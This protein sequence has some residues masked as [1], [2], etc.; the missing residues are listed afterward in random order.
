MKKKFQYVC[1]GTVE[2]KKSKLNKMYTTPQIAKG[3]CGGVN[4]DHEVMDLEPQFQSQRCEDASFDWNELFSEGYIRTVLTEGVGGIG[5]TVCIQKF[6]LDWAE[7]KSN[8]HFNF[9]FL[10][11]FRILNSIKDD[12][13][14]L[15]ELL[16]KFNPELEDLSYLF[17][18]EH[19]KVLFIFDGLDESQL[20]FRFK[21]TIQGQSNTQ[22]VETVITSLIKGEVLPS[23]K[24]LITSRPAATR[25]IPREHIHLVLEAQGFSDLQKEQYFRKNLDITL[26]TQVIKH[27]KS[28]KSL[29]IMCHMP[30]FCWISAT[31]YMDLQRTG[32]WKSNSTEFPTTL[33]EM[34]IH[35]LNVQLKIKN[36]KLCDKYEDNRFLLW[37]K[38]K[39]SV[40]KLAKLA[41][42][43]LDEN[44]F[45][46]SDNH[47]ESHGIDVNEATAYS[48]ILP[49][50]S[51][52]DAIFFKT[53]MYC[54]VHP[55]IQ[56]FLA[57]LYVFHAFATQDMSDLRSLVSIKFNALP[58]R[59]PLHAVLNKAVDGALGSANGHLDLFLR[60]LLGLSVDCS[61]ELLLGL[62]SKKVPSSNSIK[63]A[64]KT[65]NEKYKEDLPPERCINLFYCLLEMK[66][67]T[68]YQEIKEYV[69]SGRTELSPAHCSALASILLMSEEP[70][71]EFDLRKYNTS[72]EGYRRLVPVVKWCKKAV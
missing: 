67:T 49:E 19:F 41:L 38:N 13:L 52:N 39:Q 5:K 66:N 16:L 15:H 50:I 9:V 46:F 65:I 2:G 71:E 42:E 11:T 45:M 21:N 27:I 60:F 7:G 69:M 10:L 56:E 23:A 43:Q 35:F 4:P 14:S 68:L 33:T 64:C 18:S 40:M 70:L 29:F 36:K 62:L 8:Q 61:Q 55:I 1:E 22:T 44:N 32:R 3:E 51:Q 37:D 17:A 53:K 58:P 59:V 31:V 6:I 54:F 26:A 28:T 34:L 57:A 24:I 63:E 25:Q 20:N 72:E 47:L 12:Q 30:L 48:G